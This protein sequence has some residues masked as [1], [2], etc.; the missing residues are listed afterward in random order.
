MFLGLILFQILTSIYS[1]EEPSESIT[2]VFVK[3]SGK[4]ENSGL[5]IDQEKPSLNGAYKKL[6]ND[7][8]CNMKIVY[9]D[10]PLT[11]DGITFNKYQEISIKGVNGDG[12]GNTEV[13]IDCDIH[14]GSN[15]F[16]FRI[17]A[18]IKNLAFHFPTTLR[19]ESQEYGSYDLISGSG[20]KPSISNC[21][22]IRP[23][24][25]GCLTDI[26]LVYSSGGSLT[27]DSVECADETYALTS[28]NELFYSIDTQT[29][30]LSNLTLKNVKTNAYAVFDV[31]SEGKC[32]VTLN[33]SN[34]IEC[35]AFRY[36]SLYVSFKN[37]ESTFTVGDEGV[38]TFLSCSCKNNQGSG[39]IYLQ[40][41]VI[42]S[43]SQLNWP[44]DGTNL[45]FDRCTA[46]EGE[47]KRNIGI[48]LEI[49]D[50]SLK[51]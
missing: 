34:F 13:A 18:E 35:E 20:A 36:G 7:I 45:I 10:S 12:N 3:Q 17:D 42:E 40:I 50:D 49:A 38:T 46:G 33:G 1:Q 27:L 47:S 8:A 32:D 11:E 2:T 5:A 25:E 9:D 51:L 29:V 44:E 14:P 48:C 16:E 22:F 23:E 26:Y 28:E 41:Q 31:S 15:L 4:D 30:I 43:A 21:R 6:E 19:N 24:V 39:G 37:G